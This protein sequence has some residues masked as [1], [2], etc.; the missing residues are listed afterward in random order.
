MTLYSVAKASGHLGGAGYANLSFHVNAINSD[1]WGTLESL[2]Q[3]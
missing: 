3:S 2:V 1:V